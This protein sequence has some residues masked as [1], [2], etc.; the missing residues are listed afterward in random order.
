MSAALQL[1]GQSRDWDELAELDPYWVIC[2]APD[3]RFGGWRPDDFFAT[4]EA[5]IEE[6]LGEAQELGRPQRREVALDFGCGLGRLTRAL[7]ER[8]ESCV[9]V[10]ISERMVE[11]ARECNAHLD[12]CSFQVNS[13]VD[14]SQFDDAR[15]DLVY[16]SIVLQH[17]PERAAIDSY[18]GEFVRVLRPG[19]LLVF[20]L[21][22]HIPRLFRL[23]WRRRLYLALR[24]VGFSPGFLYRRLH[25]FPIAMSH[26]PEPEI[27]SLLK[28]RGASVLRTRSYRARGIANAGVRSTRYFATR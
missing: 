21:P 2:T 15:F 12:N 14:L 6:V 4:G 9:G 20:Q 19:G 1:S 13:G 3:K 10:D 5:E 8:F 16:T 7:A 28:A 27:L 17:V 24:R 11:G 23:Q 25:V 22:S 18:I 26:V